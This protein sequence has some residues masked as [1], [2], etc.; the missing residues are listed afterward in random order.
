MATIKALVNGEYVD[1]PSFMTSYYVEGKTDLNFS[2][3]G[4]IN[5]PSNPTENMIWI[6]TNIEISKWSFSTEIPSNPVE[7]MIWVKTYF[8]SPIKINAIK[9]NEINFNL[10]NCYQYINKSFVE[11]EAKIYQSSQWIEL[12]AGIF[13]ITKGDDGTL[14]TQSNSN[15]TITTT[16][17]EYVEFKQNS[18]YK[19]GIYFN[20]L[21]DVTGLTSITIMAQS[22]TTE[23]SSTP[24]T[25]GLVSSSA[26]LT[27][28]PETNGYVVSSTIS[29]TAFEE[30]SIDV[31]SLSGEYRIAFQIR[32]WSGRWIR[33][34]SIKGEV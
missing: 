24:E 25:W 23:T 32:E 28:P 8:T 7:G 17:G 15:I 16:P 34:K 10:V 31:S 13:D 6:N 21:I 29:N 22:S 11:K 18:I 26:D 14:F 5:E 1:L 2:I 27:K 9:E 20:E 19:Y 12:S 4:D 33:L 30:R 3:I